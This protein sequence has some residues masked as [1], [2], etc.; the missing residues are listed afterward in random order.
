MFNNTLAR[1][2]VN[3][4]D[5]HSNL[6]VK[7]GKLVEG[8][9]ASSIVAQVDGIGLCVFLK[10]C[11]IAYKI[12]NGSLIKSSKVMC[13]SLIG[14]I[15]K[16]VMNDF[17]NELIQKFEIDGVK[18]DRY[19]VTVSNRSIIVKNHNDLRNKYIITENTIYK[20]KDV[21]YPS[22]E[23]YENDGIYL[24]YYNNRVILYSP[25][26]IRFGFININ[27][28]DKT[29]NIKVLMTYNVLYTV[30]GTRIIEIPSD[31]P[32]VYWDNQVSFMFNV[33]IKENI[34]ELNGNKSIKIIGN[35]SKGL[36]EE[37][38]NE[39]KTKSTN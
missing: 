6:T 7:D 16:L 36:E 35:T 12:K 30:N 17:S 15:T 4:I 5:I 20:F 38:Q 29:Y 27:I 1:V 22:H 25:V 14:G 8:N 32:V 33:N 19:K 9:N 24:V 28:N 13:D 11:L 23:I 37:L 39:Y 18:I 21:L 34:V 26:S 10:N 31:A 2:K 3:G